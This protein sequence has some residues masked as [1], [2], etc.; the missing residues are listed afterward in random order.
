MINRHTEQGRDEQRI[1]T[2]NPNDHVIQIKNR[3][4]AADYLPVQWRLVWFREQCP[5]GSI[6]TQMLQLDLDRAT[7]EE[8]MAW[9][10]ETRRSE[11]VIKRANGF[12]VFW[13]VAQDGHGGVA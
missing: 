12:V 10:S 13:A 7:E 9:N 4:G 5:E 2:F 11:K 8:A 3:G 1:R 6:E